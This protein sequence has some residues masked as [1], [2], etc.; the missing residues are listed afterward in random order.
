MTT[1]RYTLREIDEAIALLADVIEERPD[2]P[3]LVTM[4]DRLEAYRESQAA[5][6]DRLA[7]ARARVARSIGTEKT[8]V[9]VPTIQFAEEHRTNTLET[10]P[11]NPA[12]LTKY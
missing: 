5:L 12:S 6:P 10:R 11:L 1:R 4:F 8:N 3:A 7:A 9:N 2:R